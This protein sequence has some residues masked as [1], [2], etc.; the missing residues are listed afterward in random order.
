MNKHIFLIIFSYYLRIFFI[1]IYY[2][3]I[4]RLFYFVNY[5]YQLL[6]YI[7]YH[8]NSISSLSLSPPLSFYLSLSLRLPLSVSFLLFLF[9]LGAVCIYER[10]Y[11]MLKCLYAKIQ[12]DKK[13]YV[14]TIY[15]KGVYRF[16][17]FYFIIL[18]RI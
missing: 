1:Y 8:Y 13:L 2:L 14:K 9:S 18:F 10:G 17:L 16:P 4:F 12:L 7:Y 6:I 5:V 11:M 3:P 15:N